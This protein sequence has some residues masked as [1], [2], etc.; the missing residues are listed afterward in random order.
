MHLVRSTA[1]VPSLSLFEMAPAGHTFMQAG[2]AQCMHAIDRW[3]T[4]VSGNVPVSFVVTM[5]SR[6]PGDSSPLRFL[7]ATSH[8]LHATQFFALTRNPN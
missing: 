5:R 4:F 7:H 2:S 1:T 6:G 3:V 8:A